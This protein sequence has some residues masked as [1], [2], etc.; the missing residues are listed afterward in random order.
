MHSKVTR[1]RLDEVGLLG[2]TFVSE[3]AVDEA[4][5]LAKFFTTYLSMVDDA[6]PSSGLA[7]GEGEEHVCLK[8][9]FGGRQV[10]RFAFGYVFGSVFVVGCVRA[11]YAFG[12][13]GRGDRDMFDDVKMPEYKRIYAW[14]KLVRVCVCGDHQEW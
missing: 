7:E 12:P 8:R 5:E 14:W 4:E 13:C 1:E 10:K 2:M 3:A 6:I 11:I 9:V